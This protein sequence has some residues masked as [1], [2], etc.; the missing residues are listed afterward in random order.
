MSGMAG[1]RKAGRTL[2]AMFSIVAV[3][4]ALSFGAGKALAADDVTEGQIIKALAPSK[5]PLTRGL[6]VGPQND[7]ATS[8][9][10][11]KSVSTIRGRATSSL[12]AI[13]R[14]ALAS[15]PHDEPN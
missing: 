2:A 3:G 12:S 15:P 10:E 7:P 14:E 6:S 5:K 11:T 1:S 4:A 9:A 8:A 13:D